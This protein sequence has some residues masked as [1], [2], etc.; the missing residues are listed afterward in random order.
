M[1]D[2][3]LAPV[4]SSFG[5][6]QRIGHVTFLYQN[7]MCATTSFQL[8]QGTNAWISA[9][10]GF[11]Q[12]VDY[13]EGGVYRSFFTGPINA[14]S[15][16][17]RPRSGSFLKVSEVVAK[18]GGVD[19]ALARFGA[20]A[21]GDGTGAFPGTTGG[22]DHADN[23]IDGRI[24]TPFP[25]LFH[26]D[27]DSNAEFLRVDLAQTYPLEGLEIYGPRGTDE[28][29]IYEVRFLDAQ[30]GLVQRCQRV[31]ANNDVFKATVMT[32]PPSY[33]LVPR[34][35]APLMPGDVF[36]VDVVGEFHADPTLGSGVRIEFDPEALEVIDAQVNPDPR[37]SQFSAEAT[38]SGN[39]IDDW[40]WGAFMGNP[41]L[42]RAADATFRVLEPM[43]G[44]AFLDHAP[45]QGLGGPPISNEI[46]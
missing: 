16:D 20:T 21:T 25:D 2:W 4:F 14:R 46:S 13:A 45:A 11:Q 22:A 43:C 8:Q 29:Q 12:A 24:A 18:S 34:S 9:Q 35:Y 42:F 28:D 39:A 27:T 37:V 30:G 41:P 33:S 5:A 23:V 36:T 40:G 26:A 17:I 3:C 15:I 19:V 6:R 38:I 10:T 32:P 44:T 31:S 1:E 7:D